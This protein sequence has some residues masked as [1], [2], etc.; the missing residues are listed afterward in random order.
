MAIKLSIITVTYNAASELEETINSL[1]DQSY[2]NYEY[3]VVDGLSTDKTLDVIK[4]NSDFITT[5]VSEPDSGI[6]DAMNKGIKL[7]TGDYVLLLNAGEVLLPHALNSIQDELV[8][9]AINYMDFIVD[10]NNSSKKISASDNLYFGMKMCHQA[11]LVHKNVYE[12]IGEYDLYYALAADYDF[13][14]RCKTQKIKFHKIHFCFVIYKYE[15]ATTFNCFSSY[16]ETLHAAKKHLGFKSILT[17][18]RFITAY[19][20]KSILNL[21]E[22]LC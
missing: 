3:I 13:L 5:F 18:S 19:I 20:L 15:G 8:E 22:K 9:N 6:Y 7:A 16:K 10:K 21:R 17:Y 14:L 2:S 11:I 1:K 12:R 4:K